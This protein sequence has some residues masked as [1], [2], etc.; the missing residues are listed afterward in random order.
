MR[1]EYSISEE[2]FIDAQRLFYRKSKPFI[3]H[4]THRYIPGLILFMLLFLVSALARKEFSAQLLPGFFVGLFFVSFCPMLIKQQY[5]KA[6]ANARELHGRLVL[7]ATDDGLHLHGD[8]FDATLL[9]S[10]FRKYVEDDKV[11][12][13]LQS[14]QIFNLVPKRELSAEQING[15]RQVFLSKIGNHKGE[16]V[17]FKR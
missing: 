2:D 7:E 9:W 6:Y 17:A 3:F 10:H 5:K 1:V 16:S 4:F 8:S 13:L 15:L 12:L 11:F 14:S